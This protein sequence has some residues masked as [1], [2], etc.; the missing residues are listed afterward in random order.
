M[1]EF[2]LGLNFFG[3]HDTSIFAIFDDDIY[4]LSQERTS[5][6]KHDN[7]FPVD[8]IKE[9]IRYKNINTQKIEKIHI[10]VAT[11]KFASYK[12]NQYSYEMTTLL[13]D[14][15]RNKDELYIKEYKEKK[16]LLKNYKISLL[17][18][19]LFKKELY[20]YLLKKT[21]GKK[22]TI[23][24]LVYSHLKNIFPNAKLDIEFFEHHLCH[25][26][27]AFCD[28]G[29]EK[30]IVFTFDGEGD[31]C[32][33]KIFLAQK[34]NFIELESSKNV[35]VKNM[36]KYDFAD[37]GYA[38]VG[39][40]YSVFTYLLGF[41]P[42]ADE[43]KV[44]ALAA[45]GDK[46]NFLYEKLKQSYEIENFKANLKADIL[47]EIF[48]KKF[49]DRVFKKLK[50]PDIAAAIQAYSE[51]VV[52]EILTNVKNS[53]KIQTLSLSGGVM[54]NVII[55]HKIYNNLY[56]YIF[57]SP[58]M[59]DDGVAQGAAILKHKKR[60]KNYQRTNMPYLGSSYTKKEIEE[61]LQ[62]S[63]LN[64]QFLGE[65][66]YIKAAQE[67]VAGK[68]GAVF[69]GRAEFGPRALG[70]RS[71]IASVQD[72]KIQQ[73]INTSIK[74]RPLFQ[75]FCPSVLLEEKDR[76]FK[77]AYNN[78]HMTIAFTLKDKYKDKLP[79]SIHIDQTARVQFVQEDDNK[80]YYNL[81]KEVKRLTDFGIIINTSF[82]K[83]GRTMV[84]T[85]KQ[86]ITDFLDTNLDFM[87]IEGFWVE[88]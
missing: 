61:K 2:T 78:K 82:N 7:L 1:R 66:A 77:K 47:D 59:G 39:N 29:F 85:P 14:M 62:K 43:G 65:Y 6:I 23:K 35:F 84:L 70:N 86:A 37:N 16:Q 57:I 58:A 71:I 73:K 74:N 72:K 56:N 69:Q 53:L 9:M 48:S 52:V 50:Q 5:R 15:L 51:D 67:I 27:S 4:A 87:I 88:R 76:L 22:K 11:K 49:L 21:F 34:D 18:T 68:I 40:I 83:H 63:T 33:S 12:V 75:P 80:N 54:A 81:I 46:E 44:E 60:D 10:G 8:T 31:G 19:V 41:T 36:Q 3:G 13:R 79:G 38:S 26:Y 42:H 17:K 24:E 45:F 25:A 55:N 20:E 32:F 64:Y 28:S 30:S